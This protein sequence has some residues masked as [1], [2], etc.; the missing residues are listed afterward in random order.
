MSQYFP[1]PYRRS[2]G[3]VKV[4]LDLFNYA[5]KADLKRATGIKY[6]YTSIKKT[7]LASFKTKEDNFDLDKRKMV[8]ADLS[9]LSG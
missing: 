3:N 1:E 2:G 8:P 7:D 5:I 6:I 4:E 9:K